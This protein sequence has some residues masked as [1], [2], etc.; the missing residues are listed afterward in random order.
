MKKNLIEISLVTEV[1]ANLVASFAQL[2]PQL[3]HNN[4]PPD[5]DLLQQ[6]VQA[7]NSHILIARDTA[8]YGRIVGTL[9][10]AFYISP[11]GIKAWIEDVVVDSSYRG[12]GIGKTLTKEAIALA[13]KEKA[14]AVLL[15]SN[16]ARVAANE[17]YQKLGFSL[18]ETNL[19]QLKL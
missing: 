5:A 16:P 4:A 6:I 9:T 1:D 8:S 11:T 15:T 17:L 10:L 7:Q 3:T 19:Y 12:K 13:K 18:R 14:K 2:F